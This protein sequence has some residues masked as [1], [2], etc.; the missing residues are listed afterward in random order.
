MRVHRQMKTLI[1]LTTIAI[2]R[3]VRPVREAGRKRRRHLGALGLR[4]ARPRLQSCSRRYGRAPEPGDRQPAIRRIGGREEP[5]ARVRT[6]GSGAALFAR[7]VRTRR[8]VAAIGAVGDAWRP[9]MDEARPPH[10]RWRFAPRPVVSLMAMG[11]DEPVPTIREERRHEGATRCHRPHARRQGDRR[12]RHAGRRDHARPPSR[13]R[14]PPHL[15]RRPNA[16]LSG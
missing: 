5:A 11:R 14:V 7:Q 3:R 15:G 1:T 6:A 16:D 9:R 10:S 4:A 13:D 12:E 2:A 8:Q